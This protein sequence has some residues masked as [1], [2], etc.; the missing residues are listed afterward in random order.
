MKKAYL[1]GLAMVAGLLMTLA[2]ACASSGSAAPRITPQTLKGW[3]GNPDVLVID[4]RQPAD[5]QSSA[6]K[7][8][9]ALRLNPDDVKTWAAMLPKD[10]KIVLYCS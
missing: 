4:V 1:W 7:I 6:T 10:K 5:W 9:G 2:V 3:L 8:K